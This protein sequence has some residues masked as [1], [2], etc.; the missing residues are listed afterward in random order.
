[1]DSRT[2]KKIT[3][4]EAHGQKLAGVLSPKYFEL[5]QL[6]LE[7]GGKATEALLPG[8]DGEHDGA[9]TGTVSL[10]SSHSST[11]SG[12]AVVGRDESPVAPNGSMARLAAAWGRKSASAASELSTFSET[13]SIESSLPA[14][15]SDL[16]GMDGSLHG[17][18]SSGSLHGGGPSG[19]EASLGVLTNDRTN[20]SLRRHCIVSR[21]LRMAMTATAAASVHRVTS[22]RLCPRTRPT[23]CDY[24]VRTLRK[25]PELINCKPGFDADAMPDD[26]L[27]RFLIDCAPPFDPVEGLQA[28]R[29]AA[30]RT[31]SPHWTRPCRKPRDVTDPSPS[32]RALMVSPTTMS[33][34]SS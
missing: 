5:E 10:N 29:V 34:Y 9:T 21:T 3:V 27:L 19:Y 8:E 12:G 30:A 14:S 26:E 7:Y 17:G 31:I 1:M 32:A 13:V 22:G 4:H 15:Q 28:L 11:A 16:T 24:S 2:A 33:L 20:G 23:I 25:I 6:P 18:G